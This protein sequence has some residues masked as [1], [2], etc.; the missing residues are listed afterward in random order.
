MALTDEK[1]QELQV[2][3]L[4]VIKERNEGESFSIKKEDLDMS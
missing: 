1:I 2:G 3:V 4:D